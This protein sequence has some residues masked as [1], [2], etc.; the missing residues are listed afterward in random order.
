MLCE[1]CKK[2]LV[3]VLEARHQKIVQLLTAPENVEMGT[4]ELSRK[5]AKTLGVSAE[6]ARSFIRR[7]K[8]THQ[9]THPPIEP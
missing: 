5:L 9:T 1:S 6:A 4:R 8:V 2:E 3:T 7:Q